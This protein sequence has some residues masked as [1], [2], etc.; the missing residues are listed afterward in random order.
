MEPSKPRDTPLLNVEPA[1]HVST[2]SWRSWPPLP[3]CEED[4]GDEYTRILDFMHKVETFD[5]LPHEEFL[6]LARL[7]QP[8]VVSNGE[9][10]IKQGSEGTELYFIQTGLCSV[11]VQEG[12]HERQVATLRPGAYFGEVALIEHEP[13]N[14]S[15]YA[16]GEVLLYGLHKS[17][18]YDFR[19]SERLNFQLKYPVARNAL[20]IIFGRTSRRI[21]SFYKVCFT[22]FLYLLVSGIMFHYLEGWGY[23]DCIY[24]AI[25]TLMTVGYGDLVPKNWFSRIWLV[26]LILVSWVLVAHAIGEFL[27]RM[28]RLEMK[29]EKARKSLRLR[30]PRHEVFD[31]AGRRRHFKC[32]MLKCLGALA[33]LL[34]VSCLAAQT[35]V[36]EKPNWTD[37]TEALYF[38][39]VTL[40]TIGYGDVTPKSEKSKLSIG[41]LALIGVP[42][43][44]L[45][46]GR[47]V[48]ITYGKAR[49]ESLPEVCGGLTN[50]TF[51][52][53]IDFTDQ[54]WR[55]GAY[56][57]QPQR[58]RREQ[59]TPF[60][61]LCFMLTKNQAVTLE[62]IRVIMA[63]FSEL[64]VTKSGML[65]QHDVD[66][67]ISLGS[68]APPGRT[69]LSRK[70]RKSSQL[71]GRSGVSNGSF[72]VTEA[73]SL[74]LG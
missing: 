39:V 56:N 27:D 44:G 2:N 68:V 72:E 1:N 47:I 50:E 32:Q 24:F 73:S 35:L 21:R 61:F 5:P 6:D 13:H 38:S 53:L 74:A 66:T 40:A 65:E 28:V 17:H 31:E 14:A 36:L 20:Q 30:R 60:E 22:L 52:Q 63:N 49:R 11:R 45:I 34:F 33:L 57:S 69:A 67:W 26:L 23:S 29:N 54:M 42:L 62:E 16:Q 64:D 70:F 12:Q 37:W 43:F 25:I 3:A 55:A 7:F 71:S 59:I 8:R 10:I 9:A 18:F 48:Q 41:L 58:S 19:L 46:L 15:V 51:D 4:G